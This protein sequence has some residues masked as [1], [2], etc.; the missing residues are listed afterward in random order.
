MHVVHVIPLDRVSVQH[1][2]PYW[3]GSEDF[4]AKAK[5]RRHVVEAVEVV[6]HPEVCGGWKVMV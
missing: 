5:E 1:D 4:D 2:M 6:F 3:P